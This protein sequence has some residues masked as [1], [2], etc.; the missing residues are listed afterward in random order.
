M[1][2][3]LVMLLLRSTEAFQLDWDEL[4]P[5]PDRVGLAGPY[6]G[7]SGG[8]LVVAGG[9][10]FPAEKP[11]E[12]G[13]KVWQDE[14]Y[15]L[16]KPG[17]EWRTAG[18]LPRPLAY[19]VS[20]TWGDALICIGGSDSQNHHADV[21]RLSSASGHLER[22][23]LPPLPIPLAYMGGAVVGKT[24]YVAGGTSEPGEQRASNRFFALN[25]E[26]RNAG[27]QE[28]E[29]IPGQGRFLSC[30]AAAAVT[31]YLMGGVALVPGE[32]GN[33]GRVY[34]REML[35]Y[36]PGEGWSR[37]PD[38]LQPSAAAPS[39]APVWNGRVLLL[40]GDDGSLV[41][42]QPIQEHPGFPREMFMFDTSDERWTA[43]GLAPAAHVTVPCVSW[44][45][46]H[47]IPSGEIRPGVRS[48]R[49]WSFLL[50]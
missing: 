4:P 15:L 44:K 26:E 41:D 24:V 46:R 3:L 6:A 21:F 49:V 25:L 38:L 37:L 31:F 43:A 27:W 7:V 45:G 30:A 18:R 22:D 5:L 47:V 28:L 50:Q 20:V 1:V 16:A 17:G 2:V 11:W 35:Q 12:G 29:Q 39:P 23:D 42:F 19:G 8:A 34:L 33:P 36:R 14:I 9:A 13:R 48:P 32:Y 40:P 10:N